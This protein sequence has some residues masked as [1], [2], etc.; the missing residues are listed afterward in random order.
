[1][2]KFPP[3]IGFWFRAAATAIDLVLIVIAAA[4]AAGVI[5]AI[6]SRFAI[7]LLGD[8]ER[9]YALT[10]YILIITCLSIEIF[11][12]ATP[13]KLILGLCVANANGTPAPRS[14]RFHRWMTKS[15]CFWL[16]AAAV[17]SDNVAL[18]WLGAISYTLLLVGCL[19][20]AND[21][22]Q[23]WHDEIA[24]TAVFRRRDIYGPRP[25]ARGFEMIPPPL[26]PQS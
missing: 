18:N 12:A 21:Y 13:G 4:I 14:M 25:T 11:L 22:R 5:Y 6:Q 20:S 3:R 10:W 23:A 2:E 17:L 7:S 9:I 15:W 24:G 1:M 16:S 26:P 8:N 19:G